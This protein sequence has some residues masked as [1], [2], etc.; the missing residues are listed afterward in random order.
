MTD[1]D[2]LLALHLFQQVSVDL[3]AN[4]GESLG[5]PVGE[6]QRQEE[7]ESQE[8]TGQEQF[9]IDNQQRQ[10]TGEGDRHRHRAIE[11]DSPDHLLSDLVWSAG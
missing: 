1:L 3:V 5:G 8:R 9:V 2:F 7:T 6:E 10:L 11:S 4:A